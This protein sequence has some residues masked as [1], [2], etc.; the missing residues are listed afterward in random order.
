[1][2]RARVV[3]L[4]NEFDDKL[5]KDPLRC[6]FK[7]EFENNT[8]SSKDTHLDNI[9]SYKDIL[10]YVERENNN[11]DGDYW[12]FRKILCHSLLSGKKVRDRTGIELQ[13]VWETGATSTESFEALRK[14]I[15]VDLAIY[16]KENNLLELDGWD[17]LK[18][19]ANRLKLTERLVKQAKLHSLKYSPKYKYGFEFQKNYGDAERLD[20]KNGNGNWKNTNKLEHE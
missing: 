17:T 10:D 4:I 12:R 7:I 14:D 6:K 20:I 13:V 19:L 16:A 15:P 1:M 11:E 2:D 5:D 8:P 9:M 3:E 18:Q